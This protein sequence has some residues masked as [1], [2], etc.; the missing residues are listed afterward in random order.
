MKKRSLAKSFTYAFE[1]IFDVIKTQRNMKIHITVAI[2]VALITLALDLSVMEILFVLL[3]IFLILISEM[4]NT[5]VEALA[6][7]FY[8]RFNIRVKVIKDISAGVVLFAAFF[9]VGVGLIV[10]GKYVFQN[11]NPKTI[12]WIFAVIFLILLGLS[13]AYRRSD[14]EKRDKGSNS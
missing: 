1:G 8:P 10:F 6:D 12:L 4:I 3:A 11:W 7:L 9:A 2:I 13:F 5:M 14:I